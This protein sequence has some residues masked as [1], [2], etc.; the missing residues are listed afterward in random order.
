MQEALHKKQNPPNGSFGIVQ[1]PSTQ[2]RAPLQKGESPT[3]HVWGIF[4][5]PAKPMQD[6][7]ANNATGYQP[8]QQF[9]DAR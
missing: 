3:R 4:A 1:V 6:S 9:G 2:S 8:V 5:F 7:D